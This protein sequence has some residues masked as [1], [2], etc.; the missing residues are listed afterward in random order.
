MQ[1]PKDSSQFSLRTRFG[2]YVVRR[3]KCVRCDDLAGECDAATRA[4]RDAGRA[5]EDTEDAVQD[6]LAAR[7]AADENLAAVVKDVRHALAGRGLTAVREA[8]YTRVFPEGVEHYMLAPK[9]ETGARCRQLV[10]RLVAHLDAADAAR[11]KAVDAVTA[12]IEAYEGAADALTA[13]RNTQRDVGVHLKAATTTWNQVLVRAY[14]TLIARFGKSE[15]ERFF[16]RIYKPRPRKTADG[17]QSPSDPKAADAK[18]PLRS[19]A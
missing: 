12:G 6:A 16:P 14:G 13:A 10:Q 19:V 9:G 3:L 8:P 5:E 11:A 4:L 15:A 18:K 7:D 1:L 2:R 17:E